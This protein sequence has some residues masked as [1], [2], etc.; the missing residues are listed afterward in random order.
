M[1]LFRCFENNQ[2]AV[3]LLN[4]TLVL[5]FLEAAE[6]SLLE[7][8]K[9]LDCSIFWS[10]C[11]KKIHDPHLYWAHAWGSLPSS[12]CP[13]CNFEVTYWKPLR[14]PHWQNGHCRGGREGRE[15]WALTFWFSLLPLAGSPQTLPSSSFTQ[16]P[17]DCTARPDGRSLFSQQRVGWDNA[18]L[19]EIDSS[20]EGV[21]RQPAREWK[22]GV[23]WLW[24]PSPQ[25]LALLQ[26]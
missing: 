9:V 1:S 22:Q 17:R 8:K 3:I 26:T 23:D 20:W 4:M 16:H 12:F 13:F 2:F 19:S 6:V 11:L 7:K 18:P 21:Y 14:P 10:L 24:F 25:W 5:D 15:G